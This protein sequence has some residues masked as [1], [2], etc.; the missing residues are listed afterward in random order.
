MALKTLDVFYLNN[1]SEA[2]MYA[3]CYL[4]ISLAHKTL[5]SDWL[6]PLASAKKLEN[7]KKSSITVFP[8]GSHSDFLQIIKI[9]WI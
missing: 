1:F 3:F 8:H 5:K 2:Q 7:N 4:G 6:K 9:T